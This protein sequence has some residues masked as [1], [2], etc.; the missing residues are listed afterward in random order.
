MYEL[1]FDPHR[2]FA[3]DP[4]RPFAKLLTHLKD[5]PTI[6]RV[7]RWYYG[8]VLQTTF[9]GTFS[10][11]VAHCASDLVPVTPLVRAAISPYRVTVGGSYFTIGSLVDSDIPA[12]SFGLG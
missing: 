7:Y 12:P 2:P 6:V 9:E 4:H 8:E 1:G 11:T 10:V 3:N 5:L